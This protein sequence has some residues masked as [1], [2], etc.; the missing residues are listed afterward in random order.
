MVVQL[1]RQISDKGLIHITIRSISTMFSSVFYRFPVPNLRLIDPIGG[2]NYT[3]A[4]SVGFLRVASGIASTWQKTLRSL[5]EN[6]SRLG[7]LQARR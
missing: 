6:R 7:F 2:P 1:L 4:Y 3:T 5:R